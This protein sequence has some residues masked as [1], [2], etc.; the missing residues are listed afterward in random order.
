MTDQTD[1][2]NPKPRYPI[3]YAKLMRTYL[4]RMPQYPPKEPWE[5]VFAKRLRF[6]VFGFSGKMEDSEPKKNRRIRWSRAFRL[7]YCRIQRPP[8]SR[9]LS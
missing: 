2:L 8:K 3:L 1:Q 6:A 4:T 7:A 9:G 5:H